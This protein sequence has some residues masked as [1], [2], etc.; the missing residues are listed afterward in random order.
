MENAAAKNMFNPG[1]RLRHFS[2]IAS[3]DNLQTHLEWSCDTIARFLPAI[4]D[5]DLGWRLSDIDLAVNKLLALADRRDLRD[6]LDIVALHQSGL[7]IATLANA[8]P[9][10]DEHLTPRLVLDNIT[11]NTRFSLQELRSADLLAPIHP[12][13]VKQVFLNAVAD[14]RDILSQLSLDDAGM[15][16]LDQHDH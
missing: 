9:G 2:C 13:A 4:H 8:A 7:T 14:A 15:I 10:K 12:I 3:K 5:R 6:Y 1:L 11:R 16:F